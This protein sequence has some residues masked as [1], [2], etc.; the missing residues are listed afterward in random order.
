MR[1]LHAFARHIST[2]FEG[3]VFAS[4]QAGGASQVDEIRGFQTDMMGGALG[5]EPSQ[6]IMVEKPATFAA[7]TPKT[8]IFMGLGFLGWV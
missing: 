8:F 7:I 6:G 3:N 5:S 1:S 2:A 4:S